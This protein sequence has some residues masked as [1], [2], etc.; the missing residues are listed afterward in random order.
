MRIKSLEMKNFKLFDEKFDKMQD[1]A[2]TDLILLNGPNGYGK[3]TIFDA[4]ELALTGEIKRIK[5]YNKEL[6]VSKSEK[7]KR[8][9][10]IADPS[11]E[12]YV[13]VIL[14]ECGNEL[15]VERF[16]EKPLCTQGNK[17][18][19]DNNPHKIFD[20]FQLRLYY[21]GE[22]IKQEEERTHILKCHNLNGI[23]DF[24]DKCCFLSQDEHL[25]FLKET[26]K[27]K[28]MA[29][30][31]LFQLP[32]ERQK[33]L[34][35]VNAILG[36]IQN[37]NTKI[38]VGYLKKFENLENGLKE[39]IKNLESKWNNT[40]ADQ[41]EGKQPKVEYACLFPN[42]EFNWDRE[43][44]FLKDEEFDQAFKILERLDYYAKNQEACKKYI[45]NKPYRELLKPFKGTENILYEEN[46]L[47][48]AFRF[49]PL[50]R[51]GSRLEDRYQRQQ[52]LELLKQ[53]LD[54]R[55]IYNLNW[56]LVAS[57]NLLTEDMIELAKKDIEQVRT[58]EQ[59]QG[60]IDQ[61]LTEISNTRTI[62]LRQT[63][64]AMEQKAI[65]DGECP[66][67]G[68]VYGKWEI[69]ERHISEEKEKL[70]SVS[71]GNVAEIQ[72]RKDDIYEKYLDGIAASA[73]AILQDWVPETIYKK[74]LE[75]KKY[76]AELNKIEVL[77]KKIN[78]GLPVEYQE[79]MTK[80]ARDYENLVQTIKN[81]LKAIPDEMQE[82][83]DLRDF[84]RDFAYYYDGSEDKFSEKTVFKLQS[85]R[86]YIMKFFLNSQRNLLFTKKGELL[87]TEKRHKKL[88][89]MYDLLSEYKKA[90]ETGVTDYKQTVIQDIEPL[91]HVYTAK[92]L[93]QK[94]CGK[95]IFIQTD[96]NMRNFQLTH[97]EE[98]NQDI[99][100][101]MSSGQLA[102]VSLSF[103][104]CMHQ[105]YAKQQSLPILLIDDPVQTIDDVNMVGLVDILRFEFQ[106]T[107]IF[108][109][110]HEQRFEWYLKYKYEK[111]QKIIQ[112]YNMKNIV[113]QTE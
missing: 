100:Y 14:E 60:T 102:A 57:E 81:N 16:Y 101:N 108:I 76:K 43:K 66:F 94:F 85:K 110:T 91:L 88:Q 93:Q 29:L 62:L 109:S 28:S 34:D 64:E 90:I 79:D 25:Q 13:N 39:E 42:K 40:L 61:V 113:L 18:S 104:L 37:S 92:I 10:L 53:S 22:E 82:Q 38:N 84:W 33:E 68:N 41:D 103:L 105:V 86:S 89:E 21:N 11:E 70:L 32:E 63:R 97:S 73:Q 20:K 12:A 54:K 49:F 107:Q 77:L 69:L 36:F 72:N 75:I 52:Q 48:Y 6:G 50:L 24:F 87:K 111:A 106:D 80:T 71:N 2:R 8:K 26:K 30:G 31:F 83:L 67:C 51:N 35:R 99:L 4:L 15:K 17:D 56:T 112:S 44:P 58:L 46:E 5:T 74:C 27:D 19:Q 98:D 9:I 3:T 55:D 23:K 95:S 65:S 7:P 47:E 1:I 96:E 45:W 78:S 59:V